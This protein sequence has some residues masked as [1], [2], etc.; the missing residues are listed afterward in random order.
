MEIGDT[1]GIVAEGKAIVGKVS[2]D[3]LS[4]GGLADIGVKDERLIEPRLPGGKLGA[5][6][7]KE[8][9]L[10]VGMFADGEPI[11]LGL[12]EGEFPEG[13]VGKTGRTVVNVAEGRTTVTSVLGGKLA[14]GR[15]P[16]GRVSERRVAEG[17]LNAGK[18]D[19]GRLIELTLTEGRLPD[20]RLSDGRAAG[21]TL[22]VGKLPD[23][24]PIE[25]G[26]MEGRPTELGLTE[27][28]AVET[29]LAEG[30][31]TGLTEGRLG[32]LRLRDGFWSELRD[33][34]GKLGAAKVGTGTPTYSRLTDTRLGGLDGPLP[35]PEKDCNTDSTDA[36]KLDGWPGGMVTG[37]ELV[38]GTVAE[39]ITIGLAEMRGASRKGRREEGR[40][41]W[42]AGGVCPFFLGR[43]KVCLAGRRY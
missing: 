41:V 15:L 8:G 26:P 25:L 43:K 7:V 42:A 22:T 14:E 31:P 35:L 2:E 1:V 6:V 38:M 30:R 5:G 18:L 17:T 28:M 34:E 23:A 24:R 36:V 39:G 29:A 33:A 16:D 37:V 10:I 3:K 27:R 12:A 13:N 9:R 4:D 19:A 40:M 21:V 32:D 20:G 11:E